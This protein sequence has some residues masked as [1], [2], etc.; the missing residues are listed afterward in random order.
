[1]HT[2]SRGN[3]LTG[4][5]Q[6][7]AAAYET[8]LHQFNLY[9]GD[10]VAAVDAAIARSPDFAMAH[11][12]KAYLHLIGTEPAGVP[13]ARA[14][15]AAIDGQ[16][17]SAQEQGH[18]AAVRAM[19]DG[20]WRAAS[21]ILE[22]V[23]I[24]HPRDLLALQAGHL[25][26]FL[27]GDSR[28]LRD[29][30]L[31][32]LPAWSERAPGYHNLLAMSAFG[33]EETGDYRQAE[34][35]GR[36]AIELERRDAWAQHAVAHVMEM[37]GRHAEGVRWLDGFSG[38]WG[39][40]NNFAFHAWWH[41]ALFHLERDEYDMALQLYDT[42]IRADQTDDYLDMS[43]AIAM[44]TR[45]EQHGIDVGDRWTELADKC[46]PKADDHIF[47]FHDMHYLM[48]LVAGGRDAKA[49]SMLATMRDA[50]A[51]TDT[52]EGPIFARVGLPLAEAIVAIRKG[53]HAKAVALAEPIRREIVRI[54]GS[55][56][57]RDVFARLLIDAALKAG[58]PRLARALLAERTALNPNNVWGW[59]RTADALTQLGDASGAARARAEA[60]V[61]LA[62]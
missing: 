11:L 28:M 30:V 25:T 41:K 8:A 14:A 62:A 54:G 57:Q 52:T 44:L 2:D 46:E 61:R 58:Q 20:R 34:A 3:A 36:R 56:A 18:V 24:E 39:D 5:T 7:S 43:N 42:R 23:A 13:V 45:F 59:R 27:L 33:L 60:K 16:A 21:R 4:A 22:D 31:R 51:R 53:D 15:L 6:D 47:V 19:A 10:P 35:N 1:M 55:H 48:A 17:L 38:N 26:D 29:R 40:C 50:A 12:L 37:Q 9:V 49:A 32:A